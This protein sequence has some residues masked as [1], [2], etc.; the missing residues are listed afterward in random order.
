MKFDYGFIFLPVLSPGERGHLKHICLC[1]YFARERGITEN[2]L[3]LS[4]QEYFQI[5]YV[6]TCFS[7]FLPVHPFATARLE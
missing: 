6:Y 3:Q 5:L 4:E 2:T 1:G 7:H